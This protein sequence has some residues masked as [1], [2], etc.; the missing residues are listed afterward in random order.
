MVQATGSSVLDLGHGG[1]L[2]TEMQR[3]VQDQ[4]DVGER[5]KSTKLLTL[6]A[7]VC[8]LGTEEVGYGGNGATVARLEMKKTRTAATMRAIPQRFLA[9]RGG[10]RRG[11]AF[12][13]LQSALRALFPRRC[14]GELG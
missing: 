2:G 11:E 4:E 9:R 5:G 8:S 1:M 3:R 14:D 10:L 12:A 7:W 6:D 13:P